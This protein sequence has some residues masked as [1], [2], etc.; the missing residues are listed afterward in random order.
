MGLNH[1][2]LLERVGL[3]HRELL[4][5]VELQVYHIVNFERGVHQHKPVYFPVVALLD[6]MLDSENNNKL[7]IVI[8]SKF[9]FNCM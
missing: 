7:I 1:R 5:L 9:I 4:G 2:E 6:C 3:N 8:D